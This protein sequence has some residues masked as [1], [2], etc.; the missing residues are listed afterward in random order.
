[1]TSRNNPTPEDPPFDPPP[2]PPVESDDDDFGLAT[3]MVFSGHQRAEMQPGPHYDKLETGE[4]YDDV[5][6]TDA[7]DI[8]HTTEINIAEAQRPVP[9]LH[10]QSQQRYNNY[11]HSQVQQTPATQA[12]NPAQ[13]HYSQRTSSTNEPFA[14]TMM[15]V[16]ALVSLGIFA[17][18]GLL[19]YRLITGA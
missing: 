10:Q 14:I 2:P 5:Q 8:E 13:Q 1:M 3:E 4:M 19:I 9:P 18:L 15:I 11:R 6:T 12:F 16:L 17:V 7:P